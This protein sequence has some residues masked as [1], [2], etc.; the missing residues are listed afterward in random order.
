MPA[1]QQKSRYEYDYPDSDLASGPEPTFPSS[2]APAP[3]V[4]EPPR[5]HVRSRDEVARWVAAV[6]SETRAQGAARPR[7]P[8][9]STPLSPIRSR[10]IATKSRRYARR[11]VVRKRPQT[12]PASPS[13]SAA[14]PTASYFSFPP[15]PEH[16]S[17]STTSAEEDCL[18]RDAQSADSV[19]SAAGMCSP[20]RK[21]VAAAGSLHSRNSSDSG[22]SFFS[23]F[24]PDHP[25]ARP[26]F[27]NSSIF[28]STRYSL[29]S[30]YA[31]AEPS[32]LVYTA[33]R[34][35]AFAWDT[36]LVVLHSSYFDE[37]EYDW[38]RRRLSREACR[39]ELQRWEMMVVRAR[40][41]AQRRKAAKSA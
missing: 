25:Y 8:T 1:E 20:A 6:A 30:V 10:S 3:A 41:R 29:D 17:D 13:S 38:P 12:V 27:F 36:T 4:V 21:K 23:W 14:S 9:P 19:S 5:K 34:P 32:T 16:D 26:A 35:Q 28:P 24:P 7:R 31:R 22:S 2:P 18:T 11:Y 33:V 40:R 39:L 37:D 15:Y